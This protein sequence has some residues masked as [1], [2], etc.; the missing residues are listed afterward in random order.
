MF[1]CNNYE[2]N[3]FIPLFFELMTSHKR[4]WGANQTKLIAHNLR[5]MN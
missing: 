4:L 3:N 2:I 5:Y 1:C